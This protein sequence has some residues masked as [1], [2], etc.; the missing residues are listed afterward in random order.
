[1]R[2]DG[3]RS[4]TVT[5]MLRTD[6]SLV[7]DG[8]ARE[9]VIRFLANCPDFDLRATRISGYLAQHAENAFAGID[10]PS[11]GAVTAQVKRIQRAAQLGVGRSEE[12]RVG[13]ECR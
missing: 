3:V 9:G 2:G 10:P 8:P 1:M 13:K 5:D 12:R 6:A 11:R 4:S 7:A